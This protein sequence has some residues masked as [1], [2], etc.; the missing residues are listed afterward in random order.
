MCKLITISGGSGAGKTTIA[1]LLADSIPISKLVLFDEHEDKVVFPKSY[2][3]IRNQSVFLC[4][5]ID[6]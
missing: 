1:Q 2:P 5:S 4:L 3:T 6:P